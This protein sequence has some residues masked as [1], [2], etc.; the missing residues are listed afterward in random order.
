LAKAFGDNS[1]NVAIGNSANANGAG[2]SNTA[3]GSNSVATG[4]NAAAFGA[5]AQATGAQ[6]VAAGF[7][8]MATGTNSIAIGTGAVATGSIALGAVSSAGS[9][10]VAYGDGTTATGANSAAIGTNANATFQN[11]AAF[12]TGATTTRANQQSFGTAANTYTLAGI[13]SGASKAAQTGPLQVLT[14][15]ANGNLAAIPLASLMTTTDLSGINRQLADLSGQIQVVKRGIA[16]AAA[17]AYA[18]T[19]TGPGRTTFAVNGSLFDT[20]GG[21]GFAFVHRLANTSMPIYFSGAYGNGGGRE[22]V[23][24]AGVAWEW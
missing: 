4:A 10:G 1:S 17:T 20:T 2:M 3:V 24:R 22:H 12:G 19:P 7:N 15:D 9:G 14:S 5:G 18:P 13:T 11:S 16:A 8:A 21:A 6:S 23:G